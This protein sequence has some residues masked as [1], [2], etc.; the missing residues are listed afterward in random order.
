MS[1]SATNL[2]GDIESHMLAGPNNVNPALEFNPRCLTRDINL[3]WSN[4][5]RVPDIEFLLSCPNVDCLEK[6]ADGWELP[7]DQPQP[8]LHASGHFAIGGL[9]NDPFAS[10]GDPVF[11]LHHA[12]IDRLW[13]IWQGQ[14]AKERLFQVGGTKT[15]FDGMCDLFVDLLSAPFCCER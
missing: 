10:P 1:T 8:L 12:Q 6:R 7:A 15:P 3:F 4:Q 5:T 14:D 11:Y 2:T 13:T 9:Q